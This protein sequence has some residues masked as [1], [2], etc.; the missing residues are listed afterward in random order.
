MRSSTLPTAH[1]KVITQLGNVGAKMIVVLDSG[2]MR[3]SPSVAQNPDAIE[4][5]KD[6]ADLQLKAAM[7]SVQKNLHDS[8]SSTKVGGNLARTI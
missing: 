4:K 1:V 5:L 3:L 6:A 2:A 8:G 7:D